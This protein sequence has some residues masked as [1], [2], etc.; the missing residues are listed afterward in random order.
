MKK[1]KEKPDDKSERKMM[2]LPIRKKHEKAL[3]PSVKKPK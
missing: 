3:P 1:K 2:P